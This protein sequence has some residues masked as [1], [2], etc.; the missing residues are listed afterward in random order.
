M[1][2]A[3]SGSVGTGKTTLSK[4]LA[5]KLGYKYVDVSAIIRKHR[6]SEGYDKVKKCEIV[7]V[8]KLNKVIMK[9]IK[10]KAV[11]DS[12][13]SHYLPKKYV[14]LVIITK[15]NLKALEKRLQKKKYDK[16]KIK[17]NLEVEI[18]D[19]CLNEAKDAG[20]K[21]L[22][23]DTTKKVNINSLVRKIK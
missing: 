8:K 14:D 12:H 16:K 19:V 3:V 11:I 22:V 23:V 15:C 17:E 5:K 4:K 9:E 20:H 13:L 1:I 18:F 10:D 2:I 7:D 21:V 6:L